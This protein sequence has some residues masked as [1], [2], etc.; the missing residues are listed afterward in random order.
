MPEGYLYYC[1]T[2]AMQYRLPLGY[3]IPMEPNTPV[4]GYCQ[5]CGYGAPFIGRIR[6][7]EAAKHGIDLN[8]CHG[9]TV[10]KEGAHA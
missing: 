5:V 1:D 9:V 7:E 4:A 10:Q 3:G 6:V 2:C 8:K